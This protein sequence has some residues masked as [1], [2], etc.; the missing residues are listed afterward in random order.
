MTTS[1]LLLVIA[2]FVI[3][4]LSGLLLAALLQMA[5]NDDWRKPP[6]DAKGLHPLDLPTH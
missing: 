3:G 6:L 2:G 4:G 1:T 5:R